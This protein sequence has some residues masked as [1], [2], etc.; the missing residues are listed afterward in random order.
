MLEIY[1][2][3]S[4]N[5][6]NSIS[7]Y[8][9]LT[10]RVFDTLAY[11][12]ENPAT[13]IIK[14]SDIIESN[15]A[16]NTYASFQVQDD[17]ANATSSYTTDASIPVS[18]TVCNF[19]DR[20]SY[21]G[22]LIKSAIYFQDKSVF[23]IKEIAEAISSY[24][25][26]Y[27]YSQEPYSDLIDGIVVNSSLNYGLAEI[28]KVVYS[29]DDLPIDS[30]FYT[31][32]LKVIGINYNFSD[33]PA[34]KL[35]WLI[36]NYLSIRKHRGTKDSIIALLRSMDFKFIEDPSNPCPIEISYKNDYPIRNNII[37]KNSS[38]LRIVY[39]NIPTDFY[40]LVYKMLGKVI[41]T[42]IKYELLS[43]ILRVSD[44]V[45]SFVDRI[46]PINPDISTIT[47]QDF[48]SLEGSIVYRGFHERE[49]SYIYDERESSWRE[50]DHFDDYAYIE[51]HISDEMYA[52][53]SRYES[54]QGV[55]DE[56]FPA[57]NYRVF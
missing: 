16:I 55:S 19:Y 49:L 38:V 51:L 40:D 13:V 54:R 22:F 23:R 14:V 50:K 43:K 17:M 11:V 2:S 4:Q 9:D 5:D 18:D 35:K 52:D 7:D 24:F 8:G 37:L 36:R 30:Y 29:I 39:E 44:I 53:V 27:F 3:L 28:I 45:A 15:S 6:Q 56:A 25:P 42:G 34:D 47:I 12:S 31:K 41:P 26:D 48:F 57:D 32:L 46:L 1:A 20:I 21:R 10:P 33:Y